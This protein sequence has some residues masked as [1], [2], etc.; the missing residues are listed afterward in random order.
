M[1]YVTGD[2]HGNFGHRFNTENFPEQKEM[3]KDDHVIICGDYGGVWDK[4]E[5]KEEKH[6]FKWFEGR[7]YSLFG[8]CSCLCSGEVGSYSNSNNLLASRTTLS[9]F[10]YTTWKIL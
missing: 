1:I 7:S 8:L 4:E 9:E 6:W 3:T 5:S 2:T 10:I